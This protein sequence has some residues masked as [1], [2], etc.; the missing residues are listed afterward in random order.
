MSDATAR[1][2]TDKDALTLATGY[3]RLLEADSLLHVLAHALHDR[4]DES[5]SADYSNVIDAA[6]EKLRAT[7][8][9]LDYAGFN[10]CSRLELERQEVAS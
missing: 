2:I 1:T 4:C 3:D 5:D 7:W 8:E 9:A 10:T 6:R